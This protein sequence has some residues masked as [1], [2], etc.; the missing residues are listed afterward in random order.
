MRKNLN[1]NRK[2][3]QVRGLFNMALV[4]KGEGSNRFSSLGSLKKFENI[5][6]SSIF[7]FLH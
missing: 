2:T 6:L 7:R 1:K 3:A 5:E 4:P